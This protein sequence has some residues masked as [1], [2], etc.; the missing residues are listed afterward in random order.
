[1]KLLLSSI[2]ELCTKN[3]NWIYLLSAGGFGLKSEAQRISRSI[4]DDVVDKAVETAELVGAV[5]DD[6]DDGDVSILF[7]NI[8]EW[9]VPSRRPVRMGLL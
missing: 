3:S 9:H 6:S 5:S 7:W 1:M 4:L 2:N 8:S